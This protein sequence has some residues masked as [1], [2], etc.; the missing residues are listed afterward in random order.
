MKVCNKCKESYSNDF[1]FCPKCG[2]EVVFDEKASEQEDLA[3]IYN[4]GEKYYNG[5]GVI[6]DFEKARELYQKAAEQGYGPAQ[7]AL[8]L[9]YFS[10]EGGGLDYVTAFEW[11]LKAADQE[12]PE[13]DAQ[14]YLGFMYEYGF[15]VQIDYEKS[16]L[17]YEKAADRGHFKAKEGLKRVESKLNKKHEIQQKEVVKV[18]PPSVKSNEVRQSTTEQNHNKT[19]NNLN[20]NKKALTDK[21]N[22]NN[23]NEKSLNRS[24][25]RHI[26][27]TEKPIIRLNFAPPVATETEMEAFAKIC[28][29]A[30]HGI[31]Y[32]GNWQILGYSYPKKGFFSSFFSSKNSKRTKSDILKELLVDTI[33][34]AGFNVIDPSS[35]SLRNR[36]L[37]YLKRNDIV[38][39]N[40]D[41][42]KG[43]D[44]CFSH[45]VFPASDYLKDAGG[46]SKGE[47]ERLENALKMIELSY[48]DIFLEI[49]KDH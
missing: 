38:L 32:E 16:R 24:E 9:M 18:I 4:L 23:G 5:K 1:T 17:F 47:G 7:L 6:Q 27:E 20:K 19:N 11:F 21:D 46:V 42:Q 13:I 12:F 22:D 36:V 43:V 26:N 49:F 2:N 31:Q 10:G 41:L 25:D 44:R 15:D 34:L 29:V 45:R 35:K 14:Y 28:Q 30:E 40:E 48:T 37:E 39:K 3:S 8:A 33:V